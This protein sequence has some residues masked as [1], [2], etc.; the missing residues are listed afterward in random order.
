MREAAG[1]AMY[2]AARN[3]SDSFSP[4]VS[5]APQLSLLQTLSDNKIP[6]LLALFA[7]FVIGQILKPKNKNLPPGSKPLPELPGLPWAGRFW[8]VPEEGIASAWHFGALH[9]KYVRVKKTNAIRTTL[10]IAVR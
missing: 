4:E 5:T 8:D 9:K 10:T 7:V 3:V 6:I 1:D 2:N